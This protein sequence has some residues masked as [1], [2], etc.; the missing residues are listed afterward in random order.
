MLSKLALLCASAAAVATAQT[1]FQA[2]L[3]GDAYKQAFPILD[4]VG[5]SH[6]ETTLWSIW[7]D[8]LATAQR[9]IGFRYVVQS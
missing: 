8:H 2:D 9:D 3:S 1:T 4:C 5:S 6:G 7:R